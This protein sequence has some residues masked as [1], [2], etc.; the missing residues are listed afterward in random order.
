MEINIT[1]NARTREIHTS[2]MNW[3]AVVTTEQKEADEIT[4]NCI[5]NRFFGR[6]VSRS[7]DALFAGCHFSQKLGFRGKQTRLDVVLYVLKIFKRTTFC[8]GH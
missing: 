6:T 1:G 8:T 5:F 4:A 3:C 7:D 2:L